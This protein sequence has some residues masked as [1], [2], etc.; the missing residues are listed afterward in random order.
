MAA[1]WAY[2]ELMPYYQV[3]AQAELSNHI[4]RLNPGYTVSGDTT[5]HIQS[6]VALRKTSDNGIKNKP[7]GKVIAMRLR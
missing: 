7:I 5:F 3:F 6:E 4:Y 2:I 1:A